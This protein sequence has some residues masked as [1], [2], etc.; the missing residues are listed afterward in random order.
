MN[1]IIKEISGSFFKREKSTPSHYAVSILGIKIKCLRPE[2]RKERSNISKFYSS[3]ESIEQIP[4]ADGGLRLIQLA[5]TKLLELFDRFCSENAIS[6]WMD[7][8]TLLGAIR[9]KGFIPWDDDLDIGMTRNNYEKIIEL[10]SD[11][12][13]ENSD[14]ELVYENNYV[15]K[16]FIKI[17]HKN[18]DNLFIDIFPYDFYY[19]KLNSDEKSELSSKIAEVRKPKVFQRFK[20]N[21][22]IREHFK[23]IIDT[24]L[25]CN[26]GVNLDETPAIMMGVDFPHAWKNKVYDW[27]SLFPLKR[28]VFEGKYF[29]A[30]NKPEVVLKSIYGDYMKMPKD[31]YPRHSKYLNMTESEKFFLEELVK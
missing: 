12:K 21:D 8:G 24:K 14:L 4:K 19:K 28:I 15:N 31:P 16:C 22:D 25:L 6:Y 23:R 11:K 7:F 1:K 10:F 5:N 17:K 18:S 20:N 3:F 30:P 2:I 27:D 26:K 13:M 29:Y 9:H